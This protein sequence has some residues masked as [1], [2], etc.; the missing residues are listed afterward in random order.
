M[1]ERAGALCMRHGKE[2]SP[3]LLKGAVGGIT[4]KSSSALV[5]LGLALQFLAWTG[6]LFS[7]FCL[8]PAAVFL[9]GS[10]LS[11]QD[12]NHHLRLH[13]RA[14][15]ATPPHLL[16]HPLGCSEGELPLAR[17]EQ[18]WGAWRRDLTLELPGDL[19][20]GWGSLSRA[21]RRPRRWR[22]PSRGR[23]MRTW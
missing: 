14:L 4:G 12:R 15:R 9:S 22:L 8:S 19:A 2:A 21:G 5:L 11:S 18:I 17:K 1:R 13:S 23:E 7:H 6:N 3:A 20:A 10:T 16:T